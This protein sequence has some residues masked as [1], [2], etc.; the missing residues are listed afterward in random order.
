M[1]ITWIPPAKMKIDGLSAAAAAERES[2]RMEPRGVFNK[3]RTR[4]GRGFFD[5]GREETYRVRVVRR[6]RRGRR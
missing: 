6:L 2:S 1:Q 3:E 4:Q 5:C